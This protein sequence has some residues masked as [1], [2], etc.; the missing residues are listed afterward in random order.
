MGLLLG[1]GEQHLDH[2]V[3]ARVGS[4]ERDRKHHTQ[5]KTN[6]K[7]CSMFVL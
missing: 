2:A 1:R 6:Y 7:R 5:K 4:G 3:G